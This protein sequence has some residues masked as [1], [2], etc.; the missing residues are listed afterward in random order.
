MS[1]PYE[2]YWDPKYKGKIHIFDDYRESIGMGLLKNGITD[3]NTEDPAKIAMAKVD[4]LKTN[5]LVNVKH[6]I[7]DW[8]LLPGGSAWIQMAWS[9]DLISAQYYLQMGTPV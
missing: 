6:G 9:G 1:N 4:L 2:I 3:V 5:D 7:Q 8:T